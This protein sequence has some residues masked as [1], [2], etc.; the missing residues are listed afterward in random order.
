VG[1]TEHLDLFENG[2][3]AELDFAYAA[4]QANRLARKV[5]EGSVKIGDVHTYV[6]LYL[7]FANRAHGC[8]ERKFVNPGI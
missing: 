2:L 8:S 5:T 3:A 4:P 6:E 7:R 1:L